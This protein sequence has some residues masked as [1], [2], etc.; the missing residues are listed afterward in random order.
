MEFKCRIADIITSVLSN[1][2]RITLEIQAKP[3]DV[4][5]L[6]HKDLRCV[7][8]QW[9]EKRS[10]NAN[11]YCW[12]LI[13]QIADVTRQS[14]E[15]V[16]LDMLKNYGQSEIVSMLSEIKP[17]GYFK[18]FEELGTG[19]VNGREFTHYKIFK[20]SSEFD[21]RE[22][23]ILIDGV[24]REAESLGISTMTPREVEQLKQ[25]WGDAVE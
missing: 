4:E 14:K 24:V 1:T 3:A 10:L 17:D 20:G 23:T 19:C 18:Y 25:R 13:T 9:R 2:V 5:N 6:L 11:S 7:L 22:M 12:K 8:K 15:Y 21:T 16:Y